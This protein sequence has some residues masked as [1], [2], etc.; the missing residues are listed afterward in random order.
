MVLQKSLV[1]LVFLTSYVHTEEILIALMNSN[2]TTMS[3]IFG[4]VDAAAFL[5]L[6]EMRLFTSIQDNYTIRFIVEP[7]NCD[8]K[9]YNA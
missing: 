3:D 4:Y 5:A 9:V 2:T 7:A 1:F 6:R 8:R